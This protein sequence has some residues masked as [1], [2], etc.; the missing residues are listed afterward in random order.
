MSGYSTWQ[1]ERILGLPSSTLRHWERVVSILEPR[2]DGYGRRVYSKSDL[3]L[4]LR[5]RHLS[6]RRG[7]GLSKAS[8]VLLAELSGPRPEARARLAEIRGELISLYFDSLAS[9]AR[10]KT[11]NKTNE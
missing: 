5:L 8:G 3:Q 4:L 9:A 1:A 2:K 6:Q 7:L 10:L 11:R